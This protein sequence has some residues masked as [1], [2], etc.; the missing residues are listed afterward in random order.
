MAIEPTT[1]A[2]G[3]SAPALRRQLLFRAPHRLI[4]YSVKPIAHNPMNHRRLPRAAVPHYY[5]FARDLACHLRGSHVCDPARRASDTTARRATT[6]LAGL[7]AAT[8]ASTLHQ[9]T[10]SSAGRIVGSHAIRTEKRGGALI[11]SG[12]PLFTQ[13]TSCARVFVLFV[14]C[15]SFPCY[16]DRLVVDCPHGLHTRAERTTG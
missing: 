11:G 5:Q 6:L 9:R 7:A 1:S 12:R 14:C 3:K 2:R 15:C 16:F 13:A 4:V 8:A 10:M